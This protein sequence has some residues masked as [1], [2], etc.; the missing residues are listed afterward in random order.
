MHD[1]DDSIGGGFLTA[2]SRRSGR[3]HRHHPREDRGWDML[4]SLFDM[5]FGGHMTRL[6]PGIESRPML[7][8]GVGSGEFG[9]EPITSAIQPMEMMGETQPIAIKLDVEDMPDK[10][11]RTTQ[12]QKVAG[13]KP[14][15]T[16]FPTGYVSVL[17][18]TCFVVCFLSARRLD[19][20][21]HPLCSLLVCFSFSTR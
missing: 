13:C 9:L 2:P 21:D 10:Y 14:S 17:H 7:T 18:E 1:F 4:P 15:V 16:D 20:H 11:V 19:R 12:M 6:G 5:P 8:E 3:R